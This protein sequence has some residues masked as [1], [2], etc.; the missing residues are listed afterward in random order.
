[1]VFSPKC[2]CYKASA[3]ILNQISMIWNIKWALLRETLAVLTVSQELDIFSVDQEGFHEDVILYV[4]NED[5]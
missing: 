1:M 5:F 4:L 2:V 3:I